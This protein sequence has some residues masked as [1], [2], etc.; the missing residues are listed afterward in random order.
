MTGLVGKGGLRLNHIVIMKNQPD[1]EGSLLVPGKKSTCAKSPIL[2]DVA[3]TA[4]SVLVNGQNTH[5]VLE[6]LHICTA[7]IRVATD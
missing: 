3:T 2:L 7:G 4:Y 1:F 5:S 6:R